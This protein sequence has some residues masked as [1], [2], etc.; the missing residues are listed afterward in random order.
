LRRV[1]QLFDGI[2]RVHVL[3]QGQVHDLIEGLNA[4]QS[5]LLRL[6]GEEVCRRDQLSPG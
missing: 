6:V 2:H 3:G 5:K 1:F 4:V